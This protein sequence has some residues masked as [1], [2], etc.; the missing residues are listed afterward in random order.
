MWKSLS[1]VVP[2]KESMLLWDQATWSWS[3]Y[4]NFTQLQ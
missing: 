1:A 3:T 2:N 4:I